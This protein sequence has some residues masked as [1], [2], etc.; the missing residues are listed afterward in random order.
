MPPTSASTT[1]PTTRV[2]E[3][4]ASAV[5]ALGGAERAGQVRMAEAVSRALADEEHLLVQAGT[6]TGK[7][8]AYL[9]PA[10][11]H[12]DRVVVATATLALQHQLVERDLPRL[13]EAVA[14]DDSVRDVDTSYAVLKGRS[15]Y[16]CLHRV[17]EGVPDDQGTLVQM[18]EGSMGQKVLEL[19]AWAEE[20]AEESGSGERD[21]APR[22]TDREWRQ[23]SVSHREC[24]G[25]TK[26]PFGQ[27]CFAEL[28]KEKAQ[29]S[30]LIITNHSLLAIDAIEGVPMIPEYDA[31]VIDEAHELTAR[32]T[33]AATDELWAAEVERAARRSQ[34]HVEGSQADDLADA[35]EAL[36]S[37]MTDARPGRFERMPQEL[38]D[39]LVLVRDAAR[40]C[41]SAYPKGEDKSDK[42]ADPGLTQAK[43]SVQDVFATAERMAADLDSDVLWLTEGTE[44]MPPRL[45]VAPLQVWGPMR[46]KLLREKSVVFTSATLMLGGDFG[47][48]ATS[49]GLKPSERV[50]EETADAQR[51]DTVL[52]WRGI[53]VGS[54]FDYGQQGILYVARHLPPPGRDGL[55]A[56]QLDEIVELIDAADGRALGLFSSRRA[57]ETAA[58]AV[59][60]R[61]PHLTTLA[62]G[63]AQLPELA[64]QFVEDPHTVLFGTL[65]L[66]QGLDVPGDTCQLVLID[67]IPFPRPDDPLMSARQ[68]AA[69]QAGGNGF[70]Q[71]AAT[72]AALLMA[73][74]AGRLI[75]TTTD[76]GVVAVLDPRLATA[77]YGGFLKASLPPMW[78]TTDPSIVRKALARLSASAK[79]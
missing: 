14:K 35:A 67:R 13:V 76:R 38:G 27:E 2:S 33:Q 22:H 66:W 25:A 77:R 24:L 52:P 26:C 56:A 44:R 60:E 8:L 75:R 41:L 10:L 30:H 32:V 70:M 74:G 64:K 15:N 58:E 34:R 63:D 23:V 46:D 49:V 57:A 43:G 72:H 28:A 12:P 79:D 78:T 40:A 47:S 48:V 4:L 50:V 20:Q 42:S 17:R 61:L 21:N 6:G 1:S 3:V 7:S 55:V 18:P 31:V 36:R 39:A 9:V 73:Q 68:K 37:A 51:T 54:P 62:Q 65:S 11:L 16:A 53:D 69:D 5:R 19:R 59:R 29:R 45:C 71:I